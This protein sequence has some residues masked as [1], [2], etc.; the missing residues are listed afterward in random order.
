MNIEFS[1]SMMCAYFSNIEKEIKKLDKCNIDSYHIDIM[2]GYFVDS[3][4]MGL[5]DLNV[6]RKLTN[7]KIEVHLMAKY[8]D[9]LLH[10]FD[11]DL[12]DTL[13]IHCESDGDTGILLSKIKK[14]GIIPGLAINPGTSIEYAKELFNFT[15]KVLVMCVNPGYAGQSFLPFVDSK[16]QKL[17]KFKEREKFKIVLDGSCSPSRIE[18]YAGIGVDGFVLGTSAIFGKNL[19]YCEIINDLRNKLNNRKVLAQE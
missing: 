2:D 15:D 1:P 3:I 17:L 10:L 19:S 7:K 11:K 13:Y 5:Q 6:L 18:K 14:N 8:P 4:A 16:I 12:V 9:K